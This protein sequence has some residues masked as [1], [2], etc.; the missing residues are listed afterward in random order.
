MRPLQSSL[1]SDNPRL[2]QVSSGGQP[3]RERPVETA[4]PDAVKRIQSALNQ[5]GF[6]GA[7]GKPL[8][9]DGRYGPNTVF[10][11]K[12]FQQT[13][14]TNPQEFDGRV[15]PKTIDKLDDAL[16]QQKPRPRPQIELEEKPQD[17]VVNFSGVGDAALEGQPD[18]ASRANFLIRN[19]SAYL[20]S[21]RPLQAICFFGGRGG[22]DRSEEA[23]RQVVALR[24]ER[25]TGVT[26]VIG[27]SVG[28]F[29]ALQT[30]AKLTARSIKLDYVAIND[31]AFFAHRELQDIQSFN[32]LLIKS[33]GNIVASRMQNFFQTFGHEILAQQ[34][35][36]GGIMP[37]AEFHGRISGFSENIDVSKRPS[38]QTVIKIWN[39]IPRSGNPTNLPLAVRKPIAIKAHVAAV[40]DGFPD[41]NAVL[42]SLIRP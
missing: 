18:P 10:A 15:G 35:G 37:G 11:V 25:L 26:I 4:D 40:H 34:G 9:E 41:I 16:A 20:L 23:V 27:I 19:T 1:L 31:G 30:A 6:T 3:I 8:E 12:Q 28:G 29:A 42:D 7:D 38:M 39:A 36:P 2:R 5:L 24:A 14:F 13:V 17:I 32:P 21:H 22:K 33:P